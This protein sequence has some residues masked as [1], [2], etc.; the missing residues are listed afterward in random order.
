MAVLIGNTEPSASKIQ[1]MRDAIKDLY[2]VM[3]KNT[4]LDPSGISRNTLGSLLH[5]YRNL[6]STIPYVGKEEV[7]FNGQG[8]ERDL[9]VGKEKVNQ[10]LFFAASALKE[11]YMMPSKVRKTLEKLI[12][13]KPNVYKRKK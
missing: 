2:D 6:K 3:D 1:K 4:S 10:A 13:Y 7:I 12:D 8:E 5:D 11:S 9:R